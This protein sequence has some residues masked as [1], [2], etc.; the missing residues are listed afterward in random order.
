[1][2]RAWNV[3]KYLKN[4][5]VKNKLYGKSGGAEIDNDYCSFDLCWL[6]RQTVTVQCYS[7][8]LTT[9]SRDLSEMQA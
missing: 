4:K 8:M 3:Q 5:L 7:L 2:I 1:M 6:W 9:G